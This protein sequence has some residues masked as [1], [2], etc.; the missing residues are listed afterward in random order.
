M[1]KM[2]MKRVRAFAGTLM[3]LGVTLA[4]CGASEPKGTVGGIVREQVVNGTVRVVA[5]GVAYE[6][7]AGHGTVTIREGDRV[8]ASTKVISGRR[9]AL[10]VPPGSY[11]I[12]LHCAAPTPIIGVAV[13]NS[14]HITVRPNKP[15]HANL[16]CLISSGVG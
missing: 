9:F 14:V 1:G 11:V 5:G 4:A 16:R 12:S 3:V 13:A 2:T 8:V 6:T 15:T 7:V 10:S